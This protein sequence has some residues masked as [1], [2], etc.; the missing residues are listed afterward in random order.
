VNVDGS[1]LGDALQGNALANRINGRAGSDRIEGGEGADILTGGSGRDSFVFR[2]PNEGID[3]IVDFARGEDLIQ[4]SAAGFAAGL[5]AGGPAPVVVTSDVASVTS[6]SP[7]TFIFDNAG[8]SAGTVY[9][10]AT[11]GSGTDATGLLV[12]QNITVIG[13]SDFHV[14]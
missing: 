1:E 8:A 11:G 6:G 5:V 9:W 10:D 7:G 13:S 12:L 3:T 2:L 4:I 14:V